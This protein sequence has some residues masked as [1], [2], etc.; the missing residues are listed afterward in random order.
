MKKFFA[1]KIGKIVNTVL[2]IGDNA[3]LGGVITNI[4]EARPDSPKGHFDWWRFFRVVIP[5]T[6]PVILLIG[7]AAKWWTMEQVEILWNWFK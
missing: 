1:T 6:I 4:T 7:L 3:V 2:R 5:A